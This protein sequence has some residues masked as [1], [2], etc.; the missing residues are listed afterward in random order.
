MAG[1]G[2]LFKVLGG[3][4][5]G[6][7]GSEDVFASLAGFGGTVAGSACA[8]GTDGLSAGVAILGSTTT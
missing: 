2:G 1:A 5:E 4:C 6:L 3:E 8:E 7:E